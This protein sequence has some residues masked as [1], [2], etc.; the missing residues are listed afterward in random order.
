MNLLFVIRRHA[1]AFFDFS[2]RKLTH[3]QEKTYCSDSGD[4]QS[5]MFSVSKLKF[6]SHYEEKKEFVHVILATKHLKVSY[7]IFNICTVIM[8]NNTSEMHVLVMQALEQRGHIDQL[9]TQYMISYDRSTLEEK[10]SKTETWKSPLL[11][12]SSRH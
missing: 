1:E 9:I 6:I 8:H 7:L 5:D 11:G 10:R 12:L 3:A 2:R 4:N